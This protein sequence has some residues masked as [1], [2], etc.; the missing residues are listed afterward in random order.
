MDDVLPPA[1]FAGQDTHRDQRPALVA[2]AGRVMPPAEVRAAAF[3][4]LLA[5]RRSLDAAAQAQAMMAAMFAAGADRRAEEYAASA[6]RHIDRAGV[7][8]KAANAKTAGTA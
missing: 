4:H 3:G 5:A 2:P 7:C 8:I 6:L 1:G